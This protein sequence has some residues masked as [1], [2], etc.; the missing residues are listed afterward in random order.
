VVQDLTKKFQDKWQRLHDWSS[1]G[2]VWCQ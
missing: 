1:D 2:W